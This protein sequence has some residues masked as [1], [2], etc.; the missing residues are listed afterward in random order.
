MK[1]NIRR[2]KTYFIQTLKIII[3][4]QVILSF[5]QSECDYH[6]P[7]RE[8]NSNNCIAGE[9]TIA[10][11][12]SG[13]CIVENEIIKTQWINNFITYEDGIDFDYIDIATSSDGNLLVISTTSDESGVIHRIYIN[14]NDN[15]RGNFIEEFTENE[16]L[17][18]VPS[19]TN[20]VTRVHPNFYSIKILDNSVTKEYIFSISINGYL[21]F[22]N[23]D[24]N[25]IYKYSV[26]SKFNEYS[27]SS[28]VTSLIELDNNYIIGFIGQTD[29]NYYY[30]CIYIMNINSINSIDTQTTTISYESS[31]SKIVSCFKSVNNKI[32]C[33]YQDSSYNYQE[34][35]FDIDLVY[36]LNS[37]IVK[38]PFD[39]LNYFEGIHFTQETAAFL[40]YNTSR[41]PVLPTILFKSYNADDNK[42]ENYFTRIEYIELNIENLDM[43]VELN[44]LIKISEYKICFTS[45]NEAKEDF[46]LTIINCYDCA[47]EK[48]KIRYYIIHMYNLY[49]YKF[50]NDI[51]TVAYKGLISLASTYSYK[52]DEE[53]ASFSLVIFSY[54]NSTDFDL[55]INSNIQ[56]LENIIIDLNSKC[57]IENN[58]FGL[59][60][61]GIIIIDYPDGYKI[62]SNK[63]G[64]LLNTNDYIYESENIL[65][66]FY[67][68]TAIPSGGKIIYAMEAKEPSYDIYNN[69][70]YLKEN[71]NGDNFENDDEVGYFEPQ[72]FIGRNSYVNIIFEDGLLT[73][74]CN[75]CQLCLTD[76]T[77]I[78]DWP[79][80][81]S[82][83]ESTVIENSETETQENENSETETQEN[84]NI[85]STVNTKT[86]EEI[87]STFIYN[88]NK[89]NYTCTIEEIKKNKC[90]ANI[91]I[92]LIEEIKKQLLKS[93]STENQ[94]INLDK[95]I[96][97]F[98]TI[99]YQKNSDNLGVSS[100]DLGDCE[101]ILKIK[102]NILSNESLIIF[103]LD[104]KTEDLS[105]T[106][107]QYEIY[108]EKTK[109]IID[110]DDCE[111]IDI[112]INSPVVLDDS[113]ELMYDSLAESGYNLFD[114]NDSFYQD[115]CTVYT[116][117]NGTDILLS[118]RK[119]DIYSRTQNIS[120]CQKGCELISYNS[121][122][123]KAKCNCDINQKKI[124][125]LN[126]TNLFDAKEIVKSFYKTLT[127]S[128]FR[129]LKCYKLVFSSKLPNNLGEILM[130][131]LF[132]ILIILEAFSSIKGQEKINYL[133]NLL[134]KECF[135]ISDN[136]IN[137]NIKDV[138][139]NPKLKKMKTKPKKFNSVLKI[140]NKNKKISVPPKKK[141]N[142]PK[143]GKD[144]KKGS[145][146]KI[147]EITNDLSSK[148]SLLKNKDNVY[149]NTNIYESNLK[150]FN[151]D[152]SKN[153]DSSLYKNSRNNQKFR[154]KKKKKLFTLQS[155]IKPITISK[156]S[157]KSKGKKKFK[158]NYFT[159]Q[160]LNSLEY[161]FAL[162]YDKRTYWQYYWSLLKFKHLIL[163]SF[164]P[165]KDYNIYTIKISLFILS[166]GL[167]F[168][169]NGFFFSDTTMNKLYKTNNDFNFL[170]QIPQILYSTI[171][172]AVINLILK[173]LSLSEKTILTIKEEKNSIKAF[174][175]SKEIKKT[176]TIR[177]IIFLFISF[178][179]MGFFWYFIS[180][181]CCVY[182]N[183]Q[184]ILIKDT[185]LSFALSMTYPF[186]LN[187]LPGLFRIPSLK[188]ENK[189]K[190]LLY[191]ISTFIALI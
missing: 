145:I 128:N 78:D 89:D 117:V 37:T 170:V 86:D 69:Y 139:K 108:D 136:V 94:I 186:G 43:T 59:I 103:K 109:N 183:T 81:V 125:N 27:V 33:F 52:N 176:L 74:N 156:K 26:K 102:N 141:R 127:N 44:D 144:N 179:L 191:K 56:N 12:Q 14:L 61:N 13:E 163:F 162:I 123:N 92:R 154:N 66:G 161:E 165:V 122:S 134:I 99:E 138:N 168:T 70:S 50:N 58:L 88:D 115:I 166:F 4:Q 39:K 130:S 172:S 36:L 126:V 38:G 63:T 48:I 8:T 47:N 188:A 31:D 57:S 32:I 111:G 135:I 11:Y 42:I 149:K 132:I 146:K 157:L 60:Y 95:V 120:M 76:G 112:I 46:Y 143:I 21:E 72:T 96:I 7:I 41:T 28:Y 1:P 3:F 19:V 45:V 64:N 22:S 23:F 133:L 67:K 34:I 82:R 113:I 55:D 98:S 177:F 171:I 106:Y 84:E 187:L 77:C 40:Y 151:N 100:I 85:I 147:K 10:Q 25:I 174:E 159:E 49:K 54:P 153:K 16:S 129:V 118:D 119:K 30:F 114:G 68:S 53:I 6:T 15:G 142:I 185:L 107:V 116:T 140:Y 97:Q 105:S 87:M 155:S 158:K 73:D 80:T 181:F 93:N 175:K 35:V 190:E 160:E 150:G 110:L 104:V 62:I 65:L 91:D 178:L 29:D 75:D 101:N 5:T 169:I 137:K 90:K 148:N 173:I 124:D 9:C 184:I 51:S 79:L 121:T 71:I 20:Y 24:D 189:D 2:K 18:Y 83:T 152:N 131:I 167:Y 182:V 164:L 17:Y 180:C